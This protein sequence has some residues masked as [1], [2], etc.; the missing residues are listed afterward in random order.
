VAPL[1]SRRGEAVIVGS[2]NPHGPSAA[3]LFACLAYVMWLRSDDTVKL[4]T[5]RKLRV[6]YR[7]LYRTTSLAMVGLP[8]AAGLLHMLRNDYTTLT[9]WLEAG[10]VIA[11][12]LYWFI[13]SFELKRTLADVKAASGTGLQGLTH[14]A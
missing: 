1:G 8:A 2:G 10:G 12:S 13:K 7:A 5:E 11:F 3:L 9:F 14:G 4:I 6:R